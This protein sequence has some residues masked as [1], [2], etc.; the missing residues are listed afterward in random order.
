MDAV[1]IFD[2]DGLLVDTESVE[3]RIWREIFHDHGCVLPLS[4]W[5]ASVGTILDSFDPLD[6]LAEQLG[7][8]P[9]REALRARF[10]VAFHELAYSQPL[11]PGVREAM[12][13]ARAFGLRLALA[14]SSNRQW[15][16]SHFEP[17]G[18][19]GAFDCVKTSDDVGRVKPSPDLYLA[20]LEELRLR[21]DQGIVLEDSAHGIRAAKSAGLYCIVVPNSVTKHLYLGHA[22]EMLDSLEDFSLLPTLARLKEYHTSIA[23]N[24]IL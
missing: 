18:L 7:K 2:F 10:R 4:D 17:R 6:R 14:T 24:S 20:V 19:A 23:K 13:Q 1:L 8:E 3:Y 15:I 21:P 16:E 12:A 9:D 11:M 22:D 5:S